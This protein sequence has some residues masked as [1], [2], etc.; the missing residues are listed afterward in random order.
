MAKSARN[1]EGRR[2]ETDFKTKWRSII[3]ATLQRC[4][5]KVVSDILISIARLERQN[6]VCAVYFCMLQE[7]Y[8]LVV[9]GCS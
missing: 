9:L 4:N 3:S 8:G 1:E 7:R 6:V 5:S 2:A